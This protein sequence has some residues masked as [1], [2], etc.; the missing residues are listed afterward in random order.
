MKNCNYK[1]QLE[2]ENF[3]LRNQQVTD[4]ETLKNQYKL[5]IEG[6]T[7]ITILKNSFESIILTPNLKTKIL[8]QVLS[9]GVN[10]L[11]NDKK[12]IISENTFKGA[13]GKILLFGL[14]KITKKKTF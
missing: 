12:S 4:L 8:S 9:L 1:K 7:P 3:F 14:K 5:T 6:F 10:L 13:L 11:T 2:E